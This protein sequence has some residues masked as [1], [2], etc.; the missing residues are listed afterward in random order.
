MEENKIYG[1]ERKELLRNQYK[2]F[3][4][5]ILTL[6]SHPVAYIMIPKKHLL[7]K[8]SY[9]DI[10]LHVHGGLTYSCMEDDKNYWIGWDYAHSG[11]YLFYK[12]QDNIFDRP[13]NHK[14]TIKEIEVECKIVI[15]Q[16][17]KLKKFK[18]VKYYYSNNKQRWRE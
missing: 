8:I 12:E 7:Y 11:D 10:D 6:G 17:L 14:W 3:T 1:I 4:Y 15:N 18:I 5:K 16:I 9:S 13:E 2:G